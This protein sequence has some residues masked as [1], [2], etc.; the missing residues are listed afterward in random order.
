MLQ[1]NGKKLF[2]HGTANSPARSASFLWYRKWSPPCPP[3][4]FIF[5]HLPAFSTL[6][7]FDFPARRQRRRAFEPNESESLWD[8]TCGGETRISIALRQFHRYL[9]GMVERRGTQCARSNPI[10]K[11]NWFQRIKQ[12]EGVEQSWDPISDGSTHWAITSSTIST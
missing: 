9:T 11:K 4:V 2:P 10:K 3:L 7:R 1:L 12:I 6:S 8:T 5:P